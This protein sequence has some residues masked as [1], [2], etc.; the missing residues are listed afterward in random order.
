MTVRSKP[1]TE[2]LNAVITQITDH[3][4]THRQKTYASYSPTCGTAYC[5]AGW[6][7]V[8][9]DPATRFD[10]VPSGSHGIRLAVTAHFQG[11][12]GLVH[13]LAQKVLGLNHFEACY[14][15][16][17]HRTLDELTLAVKEFGN[18]NRLISYN[19]DGDGGLVWADGA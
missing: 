15:F 10:Y 18:G 6:A 7:L 19:D 5:A 12:Q 16:A 8:L 4:E 14:L 9:A 1:D 3:P 11:K 13:D 2:R 17:P